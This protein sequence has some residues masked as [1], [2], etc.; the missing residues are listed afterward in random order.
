VIPL[1]VDPLR[2]AAKPRRL[3]GRP[4]ARRGEVVDQCPAPQAPLGGGRRAV[5]MLAAIQV[6]V[7]PAQ[8]AIHEVARPMTA[9]VGIRLDEC[10]SLAAQRQHLLPDHL[11]V[12]MRH[13]PLPQS[14]ES[15]REAPG[16]RGMIRIPDPLPQC[17]ERLSQVLGPVPDLEERMEEAEDDRYPLEQRPPG[18]LGGR[19]AVGV[20]RLGAILR[21][22]VPRL[23]PEYAVGGLQVVVAGRLG[24]G[25]PEAAPGAGGG[26][27]VDL[28]AAR[29]GVLLIGDQVAGQ[30]VGRLDRRADQAEPPQRTLQAMP[31]RGVAAEDL[32]QCPERDGELAE[33]RGACT[34]SV[35]PER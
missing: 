17:V 13:G 8:Q 12:H 30:A 21:V 2:R 7:E 22:E 18:R 28:L 16:I 6:V 9:G 29:G 11:L 5:Q 24:Q 35:R 31:V 14:T 25:Q 27:Q 32:A 20:D 26:R 1:A 34:S 15:L 33:K 4:W 10:P 3:S 23:V 19:P